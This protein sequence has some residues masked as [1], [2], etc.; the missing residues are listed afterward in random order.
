M[1]V[2][3]P[4]K[5]SAWSCCCSICTFRFR[6]YLVGNEVL[7]SEM[8]A[9]RW[10]ITCHVWVVVYRWASFFFANAL[11]LLLVQLSGFG[12][13]LLSYKQN[14][15]RP[16]T[17]LLL[18]V[19]NLGAFAFCVL[20]FARHRGT[21]RHPPNEHSNPRIYPRLYPRNLPIL[22][23]LKTRVLLFLFFVWCLVSSW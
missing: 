18:D 8:T 4:T 11:C 15:T 20:H 21:H 13:L 19:V 5:T 17:G 14:C 22:N 16:F 23:K 10:L 1:T 9:V 2:T 7:V 3:P 6:L 12:F